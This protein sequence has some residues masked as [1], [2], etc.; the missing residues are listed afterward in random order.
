MFTWVWV[1]FSNASYGQTVEVISSAVTTGSAD[2][3]EVCELSSGDWSVL[4]QRGLDAF[5]EM[6]VIEFETARNDAHAKVACLSNIVAPLDVAL[7]HRMEMLYAFTQK[8][9]SIFGGHAQAAHLAAP[10]LSLAGQKLI[11]DGHPIHQWNSFAIEQVIGMP[12]ELAVPKSGLIFIDGTSRDSVPSDLPYLFQY[13]VNEQVVLSQFV[14]LEE[15]VPVYPFFEDPTI[16]FGLE[17]RY[18][19]VSAGLTTVAMGA[20]GIA[21]VNERRFWNPETSRDD[22][23]SLRTKTNVWTGIG[24]GCGLTAIGMLSTSIVLGMQ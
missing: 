16:R 12:Q 24:L 23:S 5:A 20:T 2:V 18:A 22:L 21:Y 3:E 9:K 8:E 14:V 10:S 19:W 6:E 17:P 13:V 1:L 11:N 15:G 7:F 4:V